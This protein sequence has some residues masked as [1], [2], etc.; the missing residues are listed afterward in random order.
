MVGVEREP[1]DREQRRGQAAILRRVWRLHFWIGLFAAPALIALACTG[2]I[3]L[4]SQPLDLWL[5]RDLK[6]V[7]PAPSTVSLEPRSPPPA[8]RSART[9]CWTP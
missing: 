8:N 5:H 2:L 1:V 4:Y 6:V 9:W 3:I 7:T